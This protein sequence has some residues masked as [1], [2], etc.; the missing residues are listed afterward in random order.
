[1]EN[2]SSGIRHPP[3]LLKARSTANR[4]RNCR[5]NATRKNYQRGILE[6]KAEMG[7]HII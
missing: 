7:R 5:R 4:G 2:Y 3:L 1:M 6:K